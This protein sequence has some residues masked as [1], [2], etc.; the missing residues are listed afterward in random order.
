VFFKSATSRN[1]FSVAAAGVFTTVAAAGILFSVAYSDVREASILQMRQVAQSSAA[2]IEKDMATAL[3]VVSGIRSSLTAMKA[4]DRADR[5]AADL[6][7]MTVL[8]D[9]PSLLGTWTGWE[10]GAFDGKDAEF[11][12]TAGHDATGRYVPYWV[13]SGEKI[14]KDPLVDYTVPGAGD[15]YL[16]A[17]DSQKPVVIEPYEYPIDG[18]SVLITSV[19][20]PVVEDGKSVGV[21]GLDI[22]L[23]A[24]NET[25]SK[26][27]PMETGFLALVTGAGNIISHPDV[28][29]IGKSLAS[30]GDKVAGWDA[31]IAHAGI[32][33]DMVGPDGTAYLSIA[34]PVRLTPDLNWYAVAFIPEETVFANLYHIMWSALVITAGAILFLGVCG[35]FIA[36]R[37]VRRIANVIG[38]TN[39]IA[40]GRLDVVLR[41]RERRDEIGD[42]SRSLDILLNNNRR[43]V[44]LEAEADASRVEQEAERA[45]RRRVSNAQEEDV[46]F[47]VTQLA[48]GLARLSD[49]DMTVRL[50]QTFCE[51]LDEIRGNFN[52]SVEKLQ[53]ALVSFSHN[54]ATIQSGSE[55][56]RAAADNLARRTEQQAA[57]VEET[58]A[59]LEEI[60]TSVKDST[61]RAEEAGGMVN[62]TRVG[63]EKSG[64]VMREAVEAMSAIENSSQS[65]SN[66]ISVIDE[67]A[68]QTNLLAL[69]AGVEAA[70]A[71]E[72]GKGFAVVAQEVRELA[73]RSAQAAKEIKGLISSSGEH[74]K[75][76]VAL[77]GQ[78]G[79][80]LQS[81]VTEVQEIN[82]NVLAIVQAAREQSTGLQEI[83]AAVNQMD[84]ATQQ[85][86]AM[87]E[88][89]NAASH[90]LVSEVTALSSRLGQFRLTDQHQRTRQRDDRSASAGHA[91]RHVA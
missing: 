28:E 21:A 58:A 86:A 55:E 9:N 49:G 36:R 37:F 44:E 91:I 52:H 54:A 2:S 35:F 70:R 34:Y 30:A 29:L 47:A 12:G 1:I 20:V 5:A 64:A 79:T 59:A 26:V 81:I 83:N 48:G 15:Y 6:M 40:N 67:I 84:Q 43:R 24:T 82:L 31:V 53:G 57:S 90:T 56:I 75:R 10:P 89:S 78:T 88:E 72:A 38:E 51:A 77:V 50:E 11:A 25:T 14:M 32:E 60:T 68:F 62:R 80:A 69:N 8:K 22:S 18:K 45:E 42:L 23:A 27:R 39:E 33:K 13:R 61:A 63:A 19:A 46:K 4:T 85:N 76:G 16:L 3:Q 65:I 87:V 7:L 71:G 73:Q 17:R 41:D 66:I 74:V